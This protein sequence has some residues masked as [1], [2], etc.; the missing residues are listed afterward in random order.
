[1]RATCLHLILCVCIALTALVKRK[2]VEL[3]MLL[4]T[5]SY[6]FPFF[7]SKY[8]LQKRPQFV[9]FS[10]SGRQEFH[11]HVKEGKIL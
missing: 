10:Q 3:I 1:M 9:F 6:L 7:R 4:S 5:A 11:I 2:T 8:I